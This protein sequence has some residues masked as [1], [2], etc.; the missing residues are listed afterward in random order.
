[1]KRKVV[2]G[3]L[4]VVLFGSCTSKKQLVYLQDLN[5]ESSEDF[6]LS[7]PKE[8]K[9]QNRDILYIKFITLDQ[10]TNMLFNANSGG[11]TNLFRDESSIYI[12][13]YAV[14]DSGY[15]DL[16]VIKKVKIEGLTLQEA[17]R[18][19]QQKAENFLKEPTVIVKLISF[20]FT[21]LGEVSRP[22]VFKNFNNQLT[23]FEAIAM[24]GDISNQGDREN[25]LVIRP[26]ENGT[27]TFR[28]N[29]KNK[30]I[31]SSEAYY[32]LPND[33]VY[34][35]PTNSKVFQLNIP[36]LSLFLSSLSTLILILNFVNN[37]TK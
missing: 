32:L 30:N 3:F 37:S 36:S 10:N 29:L 26:K 25:V 8:Y 24:A 2:L 1:M 22:G 14:S 15:I 31:L 27:Q 21:V 28:L 34:V 7:Q 16:P 18:L 20:K 5:K 23:V 12:D 11:Q 13:G 35:E 19:I 6:V 17:H 9:I 33:I 4:L